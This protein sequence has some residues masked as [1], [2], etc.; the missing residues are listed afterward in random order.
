MV[1]NAP[2]NTLLFDTLL[3]TPL[4]PPLL[5]YYTSIQGMVELHGGEIEAVSGGPGE[6]NILHS[7]PLDTS[8]CHPA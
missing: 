1:V 8:S 6:V 4:L 7:P 3:L 5:P 2:S